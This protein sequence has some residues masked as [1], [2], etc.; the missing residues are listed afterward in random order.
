ME[1]L[2][3][4]VKDSRSWCTRG[5]TRSPKCL[6]AG[7]QAGSAAGGRRGA[8]GSGARIPTIKTNSPTD[9]HSPPDEPGSNQTDRAC[10]CT[11]SATVAT[12]T[13]PWKQ[14]RGGGMASRGSREW[15]EVCAEN[16]W[17]ERVK[18]EQTVLQFNSVARCAFA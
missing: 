12:Q 10:T 2:F 6:A 18:H 15:V 5:Q 8:L 17:W 16:C 9:T 7:E 13:P 4:T 1:N 14:Q 11:R 3:R